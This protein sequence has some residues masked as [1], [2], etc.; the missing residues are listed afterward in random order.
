MR[1]CACKLAWSGPNQACNTNGYS[2]SVTFADLKC[3]LYEF[4]RRIFGEQRQVRS[5]C[6]Y[7]PFVEPGVDMSISN[8][9]DPETGKRPINHD[10]DWIEILGAG[11]SAPEGPRKCGTAPA[12]LHTDFA[13]GMD[14]SAWR[15][16][17]T[18]SRTSDS[19]TPTTCASSASLSTDAILSTKITRRCRRK[20]RNEERRTL[21]DA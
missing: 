21:C 8:F 19:S 6:D 7:F 1:R 16:S 20:R 3:T 12:A 17:S 11:M 2:Q 13:F 9:K 18:A 15:R 5:R 14:P 4:A 10:E